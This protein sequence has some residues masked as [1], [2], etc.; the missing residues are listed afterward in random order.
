MNKITIIIILF[1]LKSTFGNPQSIEKFADSI[2]IAYEIPELNY[3]VISSDRI[4]EIHAL[5]LK[6]INS[7]LKA[8]LTDKFRIGSNTKT[9]TSYLAQILVKEGK[10]TWETTF[11]DL[12]PELKNKQNKAYHSFTLKDYISL[13]ANLN[14]WTYSNEKPRGNDIQG[15]EQEQRLEFIKWILTQ[16][17]N[18]EKRTYYFANP[19][20]VIVGLM[21]EKVTGKDYKTLVKNLGKELDIDF[22]FGQPNYLD[23]TQTWGHDFELI[24]EQPGENQKLN[25]LSSAG[26]INVSLPD[27]AKF[28]QI[29][30]KGLKGESI[31][32]SKEEFDY[33]H[34]GL[35]EFSLG[36]NNYLEESNQKMYS[37]HKGNPG[38]FLTKVY[39]CKELDLGIIIFMNVQSDKAEEGIEI[40]FKTLNGKY[41]K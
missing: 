7:E 30:L 29:Q 4:L 33:M 41:G 20:Y 22:G 24:P 39:I 34:Y 17:F 35:P 36:W 19:S 5:G 9:V 6:K 37:Y 16:D 13:R 12:F 28:I 25:W 11:F 40:L 10:I 21:L 1:S 23:S 8:E 38:S 18:S 27:Y 3:A 32:L 26:N 2:R 31:I 15:N 14:K